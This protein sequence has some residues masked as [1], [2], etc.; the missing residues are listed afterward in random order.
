MALNKNILLI[1]CYKEPN[2]ILEMSLADWDLLIRQARRANLLAVLTF[3][4]DDA[5][6]LGAVPERPRSHLATQQL[7][8]RRHVEAVKWEVTCIRDALQT[9]EQFTLLLKGA[10]YTIRALNACK[11]RLFSDVD[12]LV[13]ETTLPK[14]E[15]ALTDQGWES[16]K[17]DSYDQAY[18]RKWMHEIPPMTHTK[19]GTTI[20]VHHNILPKTV[21]SVPSADKLMADAIPVHGWEGV[22]T[23]SNVDMVLHSMTHL[24]YEGELEH[25]LRDLVDLDALLNQF[26]EQ[27]SNFWEGIGPRAAA[28][29]LS[30]PLYYGIRFTS[31]ILGTNIP[32]FVHDAAEKGKPVFPVL[33]D[34]LFSRALMP[35]HPSCNDA[36]T[37]FARW[38]LYVRSHYLRMPIYLLFPHLVRKAWRQRFDKD[39]T[40]A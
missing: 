23:L 32:P 18:Y 36:F 2:T 8:A 16:D 4:L 25:G 6:L 24:F 27:D 3:R 39:T 40:L 30:L 5:K 14:V 19:R 17:L 15:Q 34:F 9:A 7:V 1:S 21:K 28:L 12:I 33:M 22:Y 11:G 13:S 26:G 38:A 29:N 37:G 10:A 20:D 31:R 35:D